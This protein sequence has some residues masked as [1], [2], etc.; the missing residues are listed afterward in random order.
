[1]RGVRR[2]LFKL[3]VTMMNYVCEK[4]GCSHDGTY[5]SGRFCSE[6]CA[7]S[8]SNKNKTKQ[9]YQSVGNK[10]HDI[11]AKSHPERVF[12]C[13]ECNKPLIHITKT[14]YCQSCFRKHFTVSDETRKKISMLR[15]GKNRWN[16]KRNQQSFAEKY[17]MDALIKNKIPF[18]REFQISYDNEN[19]CYYMDF[20]IGKIDLEID[21][22][23]HAVRKE[24]DNARDDFM[25]KS[26]YFVYRVKW[27]DVKTGPGLEMMREKLWL[28]LDFYDRLGYLFQ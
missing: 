11:Y 5:G 14:G 3:K 28:F 18:E 8:F 25:R 27:N 16:I 21:G 13:M 15:K 26:G 23:Q 20:K 1:M 9:F 4:C 6:K 19:H 24:H 10:L 17:W 7:R 12:K 22:S 2:F